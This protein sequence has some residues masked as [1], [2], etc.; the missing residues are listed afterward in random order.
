[1][2]IFDDGI[3]TK[4]VFKIK[5]NILSTLASFFLLPFFEMSDEEVIPRKN[6]PQI[7]FANKERKK[8][9][10]HFD[11]QKYLAIKSL[12]E[13]SD[14]A[15]NIH[16]NATPYPKF[17]PKEVQ[18]YLIALSFDITNL[19]AYELYSYVEETLKTEV[20]DLSIFRD[21]FT[22][23][24]NGL[25]V[26]QLIED[27]STTRLR[28]LSEQTFKG[29]PVQVRLFSS[30]VKFQQ[31]LENNADEKLKNISIP[32][33]A[34][35]PI[36]FVQNY[37]GDEVELVKFFGKCGQV[38]LIRMSHIRKC[39]FFTI[40]YDREESAELA[41]RSLNGFRT[42]GG[43]LIVTPLYRRSVERAFGVINCDAPNELKVHIENFGNIE[44][45][46]ERK[47]GVI[48]ILM[49]TIDAAKY[50]CTLINSRVIGTKRVTTFFVE[51]EYF[52]S[53]NL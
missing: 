50:A 16:S 37:T 42:S 28:K 46:K 14:P 5:P 47:D 10:H 9:V 33:K 35:T 8:K 31:F 3:K 53:K 41:C 1:M 40:Y 19:V 4:Y 23:D 45:M 32:L 51:Y 26:V 13:R 36:V 25:V 27:V 6:A 7:A 12:I 11:P 29:H 17:A 43:E 20:E 15:T 21:P 34:S 44:K 24:P 48:Y 39:I 52:N 18:G 30:E 49:E 2:R 22:N 38:N